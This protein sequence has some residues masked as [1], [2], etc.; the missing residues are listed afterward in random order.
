MTE[1]MTFKV[2]GDRSIHCNGCERSIKIA[3][4]RFPEI[5]QVSADRITQQIEVSLNE[6]GVGMDLV[7][8]ELS[9][10]GYQVEA[11]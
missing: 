2:V 5:G 7:K 9:N 1:S 8:T 11:N 6:Q 3:L 4:E 10:L